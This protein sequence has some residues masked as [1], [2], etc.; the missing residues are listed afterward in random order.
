MNAP[1]SH[2]PQADL[3]PDAGTTPVM[4]QFLAAKADQPDAILF[5]RMG[6]FYELFF[7]DAVKAAAAL[8][9]TL[10]KR[11]KHQGEDIPMAGVP[12]HALDGYLARLIRM[13]FKVAICE[14][15][16]APAE[17][18]KRGHKAVVH[19]GVVRVVTPGTLTEDSLLDARGA[20]R[21][22]AVAVRKGRAAVAV[23]ELSA[24]AVDSVACD[25]SDLGAALAA[26][27]PSEV[28]V[29]DRLFSDEGLKGALDGSG[30]VVQAMPQ[31]LAEPVGARDR[32][33][34]LYGVSALD[35]FGA[36]EE[37]EVSALGLVAAY[38]ETTQAGKIPALA[39][40]RRSG[41]S[42]FLAIDP[43]TRLSLEIDRTQRGERDGSL[44][45]CIDRSVTSGG[46]RALAE[47]I[48]RPLRDPA[49]INAG[50]DAVEWLLERRD[51]RRDL[52]DGLRSSADVARATSRLALGRGGGRGLGGPPP[53]RPAFS[54]PFISASARRRAGRR[55]RNRAT[56]RRCCR[57]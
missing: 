43:A 30:G 13:G 9:I 32:V 8:G 39:P 37:A 18:K 50:L 19:R 54:S 35:G 26:F 23:V 24:G 21:L 2:P 25:L 12:V 46:A 11:G 40:P 55:R 22:A 6:D 17:A 41:E 1:L 33:Q 14:Q 34:R 4:A 10:T 44:L 52:R 38:L 49:A 29:P 53:G 16:E 20:N 48:S 7:D 5:F 36:F 42:G 3:K 57:T 15:L 47:R 45:H 31:A 56:A 28:L 51:L 27:R